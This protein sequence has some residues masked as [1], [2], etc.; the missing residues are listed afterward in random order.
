MA[1]PILDTLYGRRG[2]SSQG[3]GGGDGDGTAPDPILRGLYGP[4]PAKSPEVAA[5]TVSPKTRMLGQ[6]QHVQLMKAERRAAALEEKVPHPVSLK[7][8]K[9]HGLW[10]LLDLMDRP[11]NALQT[12]TLHIMKGDRAGVEGVLE[13]I[14]K[15]FTAE[16]RTHF[17]NLMEQWGP[18]TQLAF[19]SM[20]RVWGLSPEG[21]RK[22]QSFGGDMLYD[23]LNLAL[24]AGAT[25]KIARGLGAAGESLRGLELLSK[26]DPIALGVRGGWKALKVTANATGIAAPLRKVAVSTFVRTTGE[27]M[28]DAL[29][30][31]KVDMNGA[32]QSGLMDEAKKIGQTLTPLRKEHLGLVSKLAEENHWEKVLEFADNVRAGKYNPDILRRIFDPK[33]PIRQF[34]NKEAIQELVGLPEDLYQL[35]RGGVPEMR[36]FF[37]KLVTLRVASGQKVPGLGNGLLRKMNMIDRRAIKAM[38]DVVIEQTANARAEASGFAGMAAGRTETIAKL[39]GKDNL[40][41][42]LTA[43]HRAAPP[44]SVARLLRNGQLDTQMAEKMMKDVLDRIHPQLV[45][46]MADVSKD[47]TAFKNVWDTLQTRINYAAQNS[48]KLAKLAEQRQRVAELVDLVPRYVP[49]IATPEAVERLADTRHLD[50]RWFAQ[51]FTPKTSSDLTRAFQIEGRPLSFEEIEKIVKG[52]KYHM[53]AAPVDVIGMKSDILAG[54]LY[55]KGN[56]LQRIKGVK[57]IADFFGTDERT[58]LETAAVKT[59]R[60]VS[61]A[62]YIN[63]GLKIIGAKAPSEL[64]LEE[65]RRFVP[66]NSL[67]GADGVIAMM[68][69]LAD[70]HVR[71]DLGH[72]LIVGSRAFLDDVR[73]HPVIRAYDS[74]MDWWKSFTLPLWPAFHTRN[75][76]G[77]KINMNYAGWGESPRDVIDAIQGQALQFRAMRN[78]VAGMDALHFYVKK[79]DLEV[80][81]TAMHDIALR[82]GVIDPGWHGGELGGR[83]SAE[84]DPMRKN[85]RTFYPFSRQ[86]AVVRGGQAVGRFIENG[87]RMTLFINRVRKGDSF[88]EAAMKVKKFLGEYR[89]EMLTPFERNAMTRVFPFF[90]W[91]RFNVPLQFEQ[92]LFNQTS[93]AKLLALFRG[94]QV[95]QHA[96]AGVMKQAPP[97]MTAEDLPP[98]IPQWVK[99]GAGVPVARNPQNGE[100]SFFIAQGWHTAADL[101]NWLTP[102]AIIRFAANSSPVA[103]KFYEA[104]TG[105]SVF[106]DQQLQGRQSELLGKVMDAELANYLRSLRFI[107]EMDRTDPFGYAHFIRQQSPLWKRA[108]RF[109]TGINLAEI[110]PTRERVRYE[111]ARLE[112]LRQRIGIAQQELS[113]QDQLE[114][115]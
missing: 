16:E 92:L 113:R 17:E 78:D 6:R 26:A 98:W 73:W 8:P 31:A 12:A 105:R 21:T 79:L 106:L 108:L 36:Q 22:I 19:T 37:D 57:E 39:I 27:P 44:G 10:Y 52:G 88:E 115:R 2:A 62:D 9:T 25:L 111:A 43:I 64:T 23:P 40:R 32:L 38:R 53:T 45:E 70:L 30:G 94:Q 24:F 109:G 89:T 68:P 55:K 7:E 97:Q 90:R 49:H 107:S 61:A 75:S 69:Q 103:T 71:P 5:P 65:A 46:V 29:Y 18:A 91:S 99:D 100:L 56:I 35:A 95:L 1:D 14:K 58:I 114:K 86:N 77:N 63:Q 101:D 76:V 87:D 85:W 84:I 93:R 41:K 34:R 50:R 11:R 110:E 4:T 59:A 51:M 67:D 13:S 3:P 33:I 96:A 15:G 80:S 20:G 28:L 66:F 104:A 42:I 60:S 83:L 74:M 102:R 81:G 54:P 48:P 72:S 82:Y 112:T 47:Q